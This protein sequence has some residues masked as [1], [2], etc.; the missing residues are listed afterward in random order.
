MEMQEVISLDDGLVLNMGNVPFD[1]HA[2]LE[3]ALG[4]ELWS[5]AQY[6]RLRQVVVR[7]AKTRTIANVL[8]ENPGL[9]LNAVMSL[10]YFTA[11]IQRFKG[12]KTDNIYFLMNQALQS[13][14]DSMIGRWN[15]FVFYLFEAKKFLPKF[16]GI[17]WLFW[18]SVR[19]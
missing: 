16:K 5:S 15:G 17:S 4:V 18:S 1:V 10:L 6:E 14:D 11:D 2:A 7:Y 3:E 12:A 9:T 19:L 13:R 8:H